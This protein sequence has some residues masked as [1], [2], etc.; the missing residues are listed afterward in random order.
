MSIQNIFSEQTL[1]I[2]VQNVLEY[3]IRKVTLN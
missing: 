1:C 2:Y 3:P